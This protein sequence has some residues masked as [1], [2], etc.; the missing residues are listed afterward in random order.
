MKT[1]LSTIAVAVV[2]LAWWSAA[3]GST[4]AAIPY[5]LTI[6]SVVAFVLYGLDK[7]AAK[8][9]WQRVP[10]ARLHLLEVLGGWPG[11]L[12]AQQLFRHKSSKPAF[13]KTFWILVL[14]NCLVL[15]WLH[16]PDGR[17][18]AESAGLAANID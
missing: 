9:G 7:L 5:A 18:L 15:A 13:Q 3:R 6:A 11:A 8:R 17:E 12:L 4:P 14:L 2:A 16:S 1:A 10:E